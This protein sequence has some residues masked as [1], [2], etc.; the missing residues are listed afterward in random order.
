MEY[1]LQATGIRK[2]RKKLEYRGNMGIVAVKNEVHAD[3][4]HFCKNV[5]GTADAADLKRYL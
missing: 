4:C 3:D 5:R 1:M 2:A